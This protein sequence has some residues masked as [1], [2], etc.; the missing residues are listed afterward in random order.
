[1]PLV[2]IYSAVAITHFREIWQRRRS[3][4]FRV[5][6]ALSVLLVGSWCFE[7]LVIDFHRFAGEVFR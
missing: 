4:S 3:T 1:M 5:A 2:F 7:V 6:A